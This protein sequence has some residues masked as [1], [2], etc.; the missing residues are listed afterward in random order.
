MNAQEAKARLSRELGSF[1]MREWYRWR[2]LKSDHWKELRKRK[3]RANPTCQRCPQPA[4][5]VHHLRYKSIFDVTLDDLESVCVGCHGREHGRR[6]ATPYHEIVA[7]RN[8]NLHIAKA[9]AGH[10][11]FNC[12]PRELQ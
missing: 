2:Y 4:I 10:Y 8:R 11:R 1:S 5:Q 7:L 9:K 3:L 6:T 12:I